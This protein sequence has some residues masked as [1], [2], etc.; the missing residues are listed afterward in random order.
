MLKSHA[1]QLSDLVRPS[2]HALR[3][4]GILVEKPIELYCISLDFYVA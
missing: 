1:V 3:K 2:F 4:S